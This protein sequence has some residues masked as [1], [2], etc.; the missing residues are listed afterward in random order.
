[1]DWTDRINA[2]INHKRAKIILSCQKL[3]QWNVRSLKTLLY[4]AFELT[5][6]PLRFIQ[7]E[8]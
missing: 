8:A 3:G 7:E 2:V 5:D 4:S 6:G 1:M